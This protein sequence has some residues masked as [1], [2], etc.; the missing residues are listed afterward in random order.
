MDIHLAPGIDRLADFNEIS[1][2]VRS[3]GSAT[4][5]FQ[6]AGQLRVVDW[7]FMR[8]PPYYPREDGDIAR[9]AAQ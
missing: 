7:A 6:Q 8:R 5:E 2:L 3:Y 4:A 1:Q 9:L